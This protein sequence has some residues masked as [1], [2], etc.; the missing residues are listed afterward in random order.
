M[1]KI[2]LKN[3]QKKS[4]RNQ[5][6]C[7]EINTG[8]RQENIRSERHRLRMKILVS[9]SRFSYFTKTHKTRLLPTRLRRNTRE[10]RTMVEMVEKKMTLFSHRRL[11]L[12]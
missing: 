11:N 6:H 3:L 2:M 5:L 4:P 8:S 1:P 12:S 10:Y 7:A 9:D